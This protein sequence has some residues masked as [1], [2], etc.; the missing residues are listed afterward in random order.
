MMMPHAA[1][2]PFYF[3]RSRRKREPQIIRIREDNVHTSIISGRLCDYRDNY[4]DA[5]AYNY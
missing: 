3:E 1:L 5:V 2:F 4:S